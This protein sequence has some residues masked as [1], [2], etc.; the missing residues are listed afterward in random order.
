MKSVLILSDSVLHR[1]PRVLTQIHALKDLYKLTV[2]GRTHPGH[3]YEGEFIKL[4]KWRLIRFL[5]KFLS[6]ACKR[7]QLFPLVP[8]LETKFLHAWLAIRG[9]P[10]D[11][12][13]CNDIESIPLAFMLRREKFP[14]TWMLMSSL[15]VNLKDPRAF[16]EKQNI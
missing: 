10:F 13:L 11:L 9:V 16:P 14:Y 8:F 2:W 4:K 12:I 15:H 5:L 3:F 6:S 1:D 7:V